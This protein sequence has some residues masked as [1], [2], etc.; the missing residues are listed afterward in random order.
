MTIIQSNN[1]KEEFKINYFHC[2]FEEV[3]YKA[4]LQVF[5]LIKI[6]FC[7]WHFQQLVEKKKKNFLKDYNNN[8]EVRELF[9]RVIIL[10][11]IDNKYLI[12]AFNKITE[13][14][15]DYLIILRNLYNILKIYL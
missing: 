12:E 8:Q 10:P 9:K 13:D 11:F 2:D 14:A 3:L 7:Y 5:I 1:N 15:E 6:K 4:S